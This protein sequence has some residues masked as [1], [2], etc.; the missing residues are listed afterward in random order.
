MS[1]QNVSTAEPGR[2]GEH[3]AIHLIYWEVGGVKKFTQIVATTYANGS[4]AHIHASFGETIEGVLGSIL[5]EYLSG[6]S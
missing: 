6:N 2:S 3:L 1:L 5:R 4:D